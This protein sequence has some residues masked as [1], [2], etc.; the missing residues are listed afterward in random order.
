M[1][2]NI[3]DSFLFC[4]KAGK[5]VNNSCLFVC[6]VVLEWFPLMDMIVLGTSEMHTQCT[7]IGTF[8][9]EYSIIKVTF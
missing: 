4:V 7:L 9:H 5:V 2:N 1:Y 3:H 8:G 6:H